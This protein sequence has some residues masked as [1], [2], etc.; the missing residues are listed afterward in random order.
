MTTQ[1]EQREALSLQ[2]AAY[3]NPED[4]RVGPCACLGIECFNL[5]CSRWWEIFLETYGEQEIVRMVEAARHERE[6]V[7]RKGDSE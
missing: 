5:R 4:Q 2:L 7:I 6:E 3:F 1:T